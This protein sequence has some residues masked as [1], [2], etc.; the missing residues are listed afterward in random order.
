MDLSR[1]T[2][3]IK[4]IL[5]DEKLEVA[6]D[7]ILKTMPEARIIVVDD[8]YQS[9]EKEIIYHALQLAGHTVDIMPFD[10][11]FGAK[12]NR[13]AELLATDYLLVGSDDFDFRPLDVRAG[14]EK[15]VAALDKHKRYYAVSG[16][17]NESSYEAHLSLVETERGTEVTEIDANIGAGSHEVYDVDLTIN[18]TLFRRETFKEIRWDNDV[19]IG[20]G[21]HGSFFVDM[22]RAGFKV[23]FVPGV[24]INTLDDRDSREYR[25]LRWRAFYPG[26]LC[27]KKRGIR[28]YTMM[29]GEI[30]YEETHND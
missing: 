20:G 22:K 3:G 12:S 5:R 23:G 14:I 18:Y 30:D 25:L 15:M 10:S 19:K 28:K 13:I 29:N 9:P 4:T 8:G 27:F 21:E 24:N 17:V 1:V 11:G 7:G 2:I 16:R 6:L 26:R